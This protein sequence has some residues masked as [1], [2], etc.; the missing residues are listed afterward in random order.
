MVV[1]DLKTNKVVGEFH[2]YVRPTMDAAVTQ[3]C[4]ELT[5]IT[6]DMAFTNQETGEQNPTFQEALE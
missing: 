4:T 2:T 5:G 1:L 6:N 3:F